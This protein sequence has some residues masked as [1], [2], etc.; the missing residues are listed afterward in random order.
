M[1]RR[2]HIAALCTM[3]LAAR[4]KNMHCWRVFVALAFSMAAASVFA[5]DLPSGWRL[6]APS[7]SVVSEERVGL[8]MVRAE[9]NFDGDG[10]KDQAAV[11]VHVGRSDRAAVFVFLSKGNAPQEP[12]KL[13]EY[14]FSSGEFMLSAVRKGCYKG[15]KRTLCLSNDGLLRSEIEFGWGTLYWLEGKSWRQTNLSRGEFEGL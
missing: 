11:L 1:S 5:Q 4:C 6:L 15:Q 8:S 2:Q 13:D 10:E 7:D 12:K 3:L 14:R 9:G